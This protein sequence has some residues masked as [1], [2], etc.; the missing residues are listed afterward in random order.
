MEND[1]N[2]TQAE[3]AVAAV[4]SEPSVEAKPEAKAEKPTSTLRKSLEKNFKEENNNKTIEGDQTKP[5]VNKSFVNG[6][7]QQ[8]EAPRHAEVILPPASMNAEDKKVWET[9]PVEAKKFLARYEYQ[10]RSYL[11][12]QTQGLSQREKEVTD[13]LQAVTPE[14]R[15]E[16]TRQGIAI[17]DL[18]RR[19]VAWD[20]RVKE[21]IDGGLEFLAAHGY[22]PQ[23]IVTHL[24]SGQ[25][26]Q[27]EQP[28][29]LTQEEAE[30]LADE[31]FEQKFNLQ[32]QNTLAEQNVNA[33]QSF[34]D[35]KP[36]F[37]SDPGTAAQVENAV[38]EEIEYLKFRGFQGSTAQLLE[39][40]YDRAIKNNEALSGLRAPPQGNTAQPQQTAKPEDIYQQMERVR[41]AKA[42]SKSASGSLGSGSPAYKSNNLRESLERNASRYTS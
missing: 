15:E 9:L 12:S 25:A 13:V 40:A 3:E 14:V 20:K 7:N 35:S 30:R 4:V 17:P 42:A 23:D 1:N 10:T 6:E 21:G 29:Y 38:V 28:K 33:L 31:R 18:V 8:A 24:S 11:T 37:K 39:T 41:A 19:S 26:Q 22:T 36:V 34:L 27:S 5:A 16:Y 2:N 32:Q